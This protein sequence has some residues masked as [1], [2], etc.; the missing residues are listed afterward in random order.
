MNPVSI[1]CRSTAQAKVV[2]NFLFTLH[3]DNSEAPERHDIRLGA[4]PSTVT[5]SLTVGCGQ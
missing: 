3:S 4:G 5:T 1:G 2:N